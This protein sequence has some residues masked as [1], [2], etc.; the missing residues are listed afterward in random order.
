[1]SV[2]E[3][4]KKTGLYPARIKKIDGCLPDIEVFKDGTMGETMK[5]AEFFIDRHGRT[6]EFEPF[7]YRGEVDY[8]SPKNLASYDNITE[9]LG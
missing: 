8:K 2:K 9:I 7:T 6:I 5:M 3:F 4:I 1:M